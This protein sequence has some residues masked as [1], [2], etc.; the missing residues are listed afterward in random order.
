MKSF[1]NWPIYIDVIALKAIVCNFATILFKGGNTLNNF[2]D[3]CN[4]YT[5]VKS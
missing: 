4:G 3:V 1:Q 5:D 2:L